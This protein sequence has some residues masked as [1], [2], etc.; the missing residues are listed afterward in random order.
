MSH[1]SPAQISELKTQLEQ[2]LAKLTS[3]TD[4]IR[5]EDPKNYPDRVNDNAEVG[6]EAL[7][8]YDMLSNESLGNEAAN[9]KVDIE[10]ALAR[11]ADGSYGHD[12]ETKQ[13]IPFER[14]KLYPWATNNVQP[15][16]KT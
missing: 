12:L 13:P 15:A 14:L 11:I 1:L 2:R 6:E 16:Q 4:E 8:D 7:E 9:L 3:Y 5:E 10:A